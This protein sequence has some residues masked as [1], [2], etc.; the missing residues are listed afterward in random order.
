MISICPEHLP[1]ARV[2]DAFWLGRLAFRK[3]EKEASRRNA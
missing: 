2:F 3:I 1:A